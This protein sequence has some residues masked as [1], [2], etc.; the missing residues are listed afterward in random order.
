MRRFCSKFQKS[1]IFILGAIIYLGCYLVFFALLGMENKQLLV[2]SRTSVVITFTWIIVTYLLTAIYGKFDIGARKARP[3]ITSLTLTTVMT[4]IVAYLLLNIMNRNE[5]NNQTFKIEFAGIFLGI[6]IIHVLLIILIS[7]LANAFYYW[8]QEPKKTVVLISEPSSE[9]MIRRVIGNFKKKFKITA[10][11]DYRSDNVKSLIEEAEA[12]F[13]YDIPMSE[14]VQV[15]NECYRKK[16]DIH[17][18]P[19]ISDILVQSARQTMFD[20]MAV[21]SCEEKAISFEQRI[22]K[23]LM[24]I[25]ISLVALILSSPIYVIAAIGIKLCDRGPVF[26]RQKRATLNGKVFSIYKFRTMRVD[27]DNRSVTKD[28]DRITGIG[29]FLRKYRLDELPQFINILKG[30]MSVVGPRPEMME[31]V[32]KYTADMPEFKYRLRMK[33]GLTGYAQIVGKYNTTSRDKLILDL[34]YIENFSVFK[35]IQLIFQTVLVLLKA[36]DS[37]EA[38]NSEDEEESV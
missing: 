3:I 34:M 31:N 28:D 36:D 33:A 11:A 14:R 35:D 32:E 17:F 18:N 20:D 16:K 30:E 25:G 5:D 6:L 8:V 26:F 10:V 12:V 9:K 22:V 13:L 1:I 4:D 37:T 7:A 15:I 27:S 38:F 2:L 19:E 24:D 21:L 23:R 29:K